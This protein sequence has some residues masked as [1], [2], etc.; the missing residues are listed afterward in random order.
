CLVCGAPDLYVQR[1][2]D[3]RLGCL[4]ILVA[5]A[6][7]YPTRGLSLIIAVFADYLLYHLLP[8]ITICYRCHAVYRNVERNPSHAPFDPAVGEKYE[9]EAS[10]Y[11]NPRV[12]RTS[13]RAG[14]KGP[15]QGEG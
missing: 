14:R 10:G 15:N 6:L 1:D 13:H 12:P 8:E 5:V 3:R 7:S 11:R 4:V 2:F 9:V